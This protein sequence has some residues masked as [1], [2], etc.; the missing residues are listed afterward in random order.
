MVPRQAEQ[1]AEVYDG[2]H[3]GEG[4]MM[5]SRRIRSDRR[6]SSGVHDWR[7]R[8]RSPES[9]RPCL[10]GSR[11]T[12]RSERSPLSRTHGCCRGVTLRWY[13]GM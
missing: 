7:R 4:L 3:G 6:S 2:A 10:A 1:P 5:D 11:Y 13:V 8:L 9:L 12:A